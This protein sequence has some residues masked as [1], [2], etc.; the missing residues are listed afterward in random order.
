MAHLTPT[1]LLRLAPF[2]AVPP[3]EIPGDDPGTWSAVTATQTGG[4]SLAVGGFPIDALSLQVKCI[5]GGELGTATFSVSKDGGATFLP[6]VASEVNPDLAGKWRYQL[7]LT[8]VTVE[9]RAGTAPS[10]VAGDVFAFTTTA[11]QR[12]LDHCAAVDSLWDEYA[13]NAYAKPEL[14]TPNKNQ[15]YHMAAIARGRLLRGRGLPP[16]EWRSYERDHDI[17]IKYFEQHSQGDLR[18]AEQTDPPYFPD[19]MTSRGKYSGTDR[20]PGTG[21]GCGRRWYCC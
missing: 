11:S 20:L 6:P 18:A 10:F 7:Q 16:E 14:V 19:V 1:Q 9:L 4:G 2:G 8:G 12:L 5:T 21:R 13:R 15:L 17:A 3:S